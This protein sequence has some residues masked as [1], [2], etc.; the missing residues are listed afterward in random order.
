MQIQKKMRE[1]LF[2][3]A[4]TFVLFNTV[5][6]QRVVEGLVTDVEGVPAVAVTVL[7][8]GTHVFAVSDMEGKFRLD[9]RQSPP[10]TLQFSS[11]GLITKEVEILQMTNKPLK[12]VLQSNNTFEEVLVTARRRKENIQD[13]PIPMTAMIG[14]Q[15][16]NTGA[17][18]VNRL[19]E[20][21]PTVQFYSS[22]QRNTALNIRGLGTTF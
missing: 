9:A 19:K 12:V 13:I 4:L 10:F 5:K 8:K 14:A 6:A 17:F 22:N 16:E 3:V 20:M 15:V 18:N 7:V 1:L 21:T 2:S 11:V